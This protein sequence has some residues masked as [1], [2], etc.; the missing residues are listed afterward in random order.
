MAATLTAHSSAFT[1]APD[2]QFYRTLQFGPLTNT[3]PL[4]L[5]TDG[6]YS[7]GM[8]PFN[9]DVIKISIRMKTESAA[10]T[11]TIQF[12][13][14]ASGTAIGSATAI[15]AAQEL[16]D[17]TADDTTYDVPLTG[18]AYK[19]VAS[20]SVLCIVT[21][22]T[23]ASMAELTISVVCRVRPFRRADGSAAGDGTGNYL[24]G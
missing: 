14:A 23:L 20:G 24:Q 12:A 10:N 17:Q 6:T 2:D 3:A 19:N 4:I 16:K 21:G 1:G 13:I 7:L 15:T 18:S 5:Y 8:I 22:G 11:D 9:C